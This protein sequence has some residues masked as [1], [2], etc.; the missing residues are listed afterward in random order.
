MVC[1]GGLSGQLGAASVGFSGGCDVHWWA[2]HANVSAG[3]LLVYIGKCQ[4][5][6]GVTV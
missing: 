5:T 1:S 4:C 2:Q 6:Q 3:C